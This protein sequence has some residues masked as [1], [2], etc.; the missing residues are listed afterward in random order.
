EFDR[1]AYD[2]P[3]AR[4]DRC[5]SCHA[6]IDKEGFEEAPHPYRTH[7]E[8]QALLTAHPPEKFACTPCHE[9]Q[10]AAVNSIEMAHGEVMFWEKPLLRGEEV[11][12]SCIGCHD[13][14][15]RIPHANMISAGERL[16]EQL[17]CHGCHLVEGYDG[18][19]RVGPSLRNVAAKDDPEWMVSWI[20][21]PHEFRPRTKMPWFLLDREESTQAA[22]FL[23][24]V[25]KEGGSKWLAA[26]PEPTG[27]DPANPGLVARGK[28]LVE[29]IGCRGCHAFAPDEVA[30]VLGETKN[31]APNLSRVAEKTSGRWIYHWIRNPESYNP[32]T[33]MPSLRLSHE[34]AAAITSYLVT[35]RQES[36]AKPAPDGASGE[37]DLAARLA[38]PDTI[39]A[40]EK[41]VRKYGCYGCH[42]IPG[43]ENESR[44]G[45][46]LSLFGSKNL[47]E[48]FF[49][50]HKEIPHDWEN[51]TYHK[52]KEPRIYETEFIEQMMPNFRLAD[53]EI[54]A[55]RIFLASRVEHKVPPEYRY[56]DG[57]GFV[58]KLVKGRRLVDDFNC[59]GCHVID[60]IGGDIRKHYEDNETFAPPNLRGEGKK[61]QSDW[62]YVFVKE[63]TPIRPWLT[64]RMPTF[65]LSDDEARTIVEYFQALDEVRNPYVFVDQG[66]VPPE[67]IDAA[68]VLVSAD[69]FSCFS[70]HQQGDRK[71][72]G[73]PE[74]WAPD[75]GMAHER[76]NPEWIIQWIKDPQALMPGTKMPAFY[77][78]GPD[79]VF[80][81]DEDRQI[82]ALRDYLMTLGRPEATVARKESATGKPDSSS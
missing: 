47:E 35:L 3:V 70:C 16:F 65:G 32:G 43:M 2:Q 61:V 62:L 82:R 13:D 27:I 72:E 38:D 52:L 68:K 58:A 31:V 50:E 29:S 9:G 69:Y 59:R 18:L 41:L 26:H 34:E 63:P 55:L 40:G 8:R 74:G 12:A 30:S 6:G 28:A 73:P 71:P 7:P 46:E 48:F 15:R 33:R 77:P 17:G 36:P 51:W 44:I 1:N 37:T 42:E 39:A 20:Q 23:L 49:G 21:N 45:V 56:P 75:L 64:V 76:L 19:A 66:D 81:G 14:V 80:G 11:Q 78:G 79:D 53:S 60:E 25:S 57:D 24:K 4:V 67:H 22:A 5:I 10:G 54:R